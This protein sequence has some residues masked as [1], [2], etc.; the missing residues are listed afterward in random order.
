MKCINCGY[1]HESP[2]DYCLQCGEKMLVSREK[3]QEQVVRHSLRD[4]HQSLERK[5]RQF[6]LL[7]LFCFL[8]VLGLGALLPEPRSMEEKI[9]HPKPRTPFYELNESEQ[10]FDNFA[11][12]EKYQLEVPQGLLKDQE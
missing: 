10:L 6:F 12:R 3:L 7:A 2:A 9:V 1:K 8:V 5:T 4:K 11:D